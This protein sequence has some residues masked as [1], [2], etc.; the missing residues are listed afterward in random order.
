MGSVD[1]GLPAGPKFIFMKRVLIALVVLVMVGWPLLSRAQYG[2]DDD[3]NGSN[4]VD[5][6][7]GQTL[8]VVSYILTPFGMALEWG[9]TRPLHYAATQTAISPL[10]SGDTETSYFGQTHNADLLPP[11]TF[12]RPVIP[13]QYNSL[14]VPAEA[15]ARRSTLAPVAPMQQSNLPQTNLSQ[16]AAP[17]MPQTGDQPE[18]VR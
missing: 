10:L 5:V 3:E 9:L 8:K 11:G 7:D 13:G 14:P 6:D 12:E 18:M 2:G 15:T 4:Y 1:T 16:P 17:V